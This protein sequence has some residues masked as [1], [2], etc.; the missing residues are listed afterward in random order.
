MIEFYCHSIRTRIK[1]S[2]YGRSSDTYLFYCHS[3]RTRIKTIYANPS[4]FSS[5]F[6]CHSIRTRIK[7]YIS[8]SPV[9]RALYSIVI[10]LEQG[11]R[12]IES[13]IA[14]AFF[15]HSIV[16]PLEQGLS[17]SYLLRELPLSRF[18][19]H[20]IRTRIKTNPSL[21][22]VNR[23]FLFYCHSIRTRIKTIPITPERSS[24]KFYC[25]SIRT[26]IKTHF[27]NVLKVIYS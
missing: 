26:R 25:H 3:I 2:W 15:V 4:S 1:T 17:R 22:W 20:S 21:W 14:V 18:Y 12:Q 16:I 27:D 19:C 13:V 24:I 11:L 10:P 5:S 7:T 9:L 8:L 6:Y 23:G